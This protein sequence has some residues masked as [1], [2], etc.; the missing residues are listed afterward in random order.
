MDDGGTSRLVLYMVGVVDKANIDQVKQEEQQ[1]QNDEESFH[2]G[3]LGASCQSRRFLWRE[4]L[5]MLD[6]TMYR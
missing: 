1:A 3:P 5:I 6:K 4:N 2:P